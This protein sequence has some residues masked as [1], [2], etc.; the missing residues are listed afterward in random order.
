MTGASDLQ[1]SARRGRRR[2][3][4]ALA[5]DSVNCHAQGDSTR[6]LS[7]VGAKHTLDDGERLV[8]FGHAPP[9]GGRLCARRAGQSSKAA[10]SG[11]RAARFDSTDESNAPPT[12]KPSATETPSNRERR[13]HQ[14]NTEQARVPASSRHAET[15]GASGR[16]R[17]AA[18]PAS[19]PHS[20][21]CGDDAH[22]CDGCNVRRRGQP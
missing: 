2:F 17:P 14:P 13:S 15:T 4:L 20:G 9:F 10:R 12:K 16:R 8:V 22:A 6:H 7:G 19:R 1:S 18:A 21:D 11:G 3:Q 5:N